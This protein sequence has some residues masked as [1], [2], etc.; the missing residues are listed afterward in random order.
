MPNFTSPSV[1][2]AN[3][4]RMFD[5]D[6]LPGS[7]VMHATGQRFG[8]SHVDKALIGGT[9]QIDGFAGARVDILKGMRIRVV[10]M[11]SGAFYNE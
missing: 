10:L 5:A 2:D 3:V 9:A 6:F 11:W 1:N 8:Q 7:R 4:H